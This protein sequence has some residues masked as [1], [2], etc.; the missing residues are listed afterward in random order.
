MRLISPS[1]GSPTLSL[2]LS[3]LQEDARAPHSVLDVSLRPTS[4]HGMANSSAAAEAEDALNNSSALAESQHGP[5]SHRTSTSTF[6]FF[7]STEVR[8]HF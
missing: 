7:S 2:S 4:I 6:F 8:V 3:L 1:F 5:L